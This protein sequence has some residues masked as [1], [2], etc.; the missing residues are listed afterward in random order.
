ME[1]RH[2]RMCAAA[3]ILGLA[4]TASCGVFADQQDFS[5]AGPREAGKGPGCS[6]ACADGLPC[7]QN[8]DCA[9][10]ECTSGKCLAPRCAPACV[11][12]NV[13]GSAVD[14]ASA[15]CIHGMCASPGCAPGCDD[16]AHCGANGDCASGVCT[17]AKCIRPTCAPT[18]TENEA[19][20]ANAD[21]SSALCES[22]HCFDAQNCAA[23]LAKNPG[24]ASGVYEIEPGGEGGSASIDVSCDM[25][26][27]GGG[28]TQVYDQNVDVSPG[29]QPISAWLAG[30]NVTSPKSGQYSILNLLEKLESGSSYEFRLVWPTPPTDGWIQWTQVQ[31]PITA[32]QA[33]TISDVEMMPTGQMGCEAFRGL[34]PNTDGTSAALEGD[35]KPS[36]FFWA[37]GTPF[38]WEGG[39]PSYSTMADLGTPEAQLWVR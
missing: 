4:A 9:S 6:P 17:G 20:G 35:S 32:S 1:G 25:T 11:N 16:G 27:E 18:C 7:E 22:A 31:N 12:G 34:A 30:V 23:L 10:G 24:L 21:C 14:C 26:T 36:C 19:C 28:W 3:L 8:G 33:P 13:C 2:W 15:S 38:A 39:I 5:L 29:Y 37:V